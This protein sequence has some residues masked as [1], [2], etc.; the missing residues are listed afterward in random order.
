MSYDVKTAIFYKQKKRNA[1][2]QLK[3]DNKE[4]TERK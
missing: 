3:H 1:V 4:K 2:N